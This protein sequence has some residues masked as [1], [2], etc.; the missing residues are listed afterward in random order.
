MRVLLPDDMRRVASEPDASLRAELDV[1]MAVVG[2]LR[3]RLAQLEAAHARELLE[4]SERLEAV[5]KEAA[6]APPD[7]D[8]PGGAAPAPPEPRAR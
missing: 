6:S 2:N 7:P 5:R 8:A 4:L 3:G 1:L